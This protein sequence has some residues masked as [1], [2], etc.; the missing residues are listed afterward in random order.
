MSS[1][2]AAESARPLDY[3]IVSGSEAVVP[4][5]VEAG[6]VIVEVTINGHGPFPLMFDTGS[7]DTLTPETVAAL[8]LET[9]GTGTTRD[10]GGGNVPITFTRLGAV[11]LGDAEMTDQTFAVLALPRYL[12]DR[13]SRPPLAGFIGYEL[14]VRFG[15]RLDYEGKTLTLSPGGDFRFNGKGVRVPLVLTEKVPV[16]PA[17]AENVSGMFVV[18]TG[19]TGALTLRR[20]FVEDH[21][22]EARHPSALRI[23]SIGTAGRYCQLKRPW[24]AR[25]VGGAAARVGELLCSPIMLPRSSRA[26]PEKGAPGPLS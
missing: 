16:V 1:V 2:L 13:G 23:K 26:G 9:E 17:A 4:I 15:V 25:R 12:T 21:G 14:L 5:S 20:E 7:Q 24:Y 8:R 19:S 6:E 10:S 18:D 3:R 22:F 11:R